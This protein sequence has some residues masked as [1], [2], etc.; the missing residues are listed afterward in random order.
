MKSLLEIFKSLKSRETC[1][2]EMKKIGFARDGYCVG[3]ILNEEAVCQKC[4]Y[5]TC[6]TDFNIRRI[7]RW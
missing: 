1:Y 2:C 7:M 3:T 4:T 5:N 6:G